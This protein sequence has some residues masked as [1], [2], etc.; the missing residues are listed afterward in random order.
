MKGLIIN[1]LGKPENAMHSTAMDDYSVRTVDQETLILHLFQHEGVNMGLDDT[2]IPAF[3]KGLAYYHDHDASV[4][5]RNSGG[6]SIVSDSGVLNM[7]LVLKSNANMYDN[8]RYLDQFIR[9]ALS[10]ITHAIDTGEIIGAYC[11]GNSDMSINGRKF[12]GTAQRKRLDSVALVCYIGVNGNQ[13]QRSSLVQGFYE[14]MDYDDVVVHKDFMGT[15]SSLTGLTL[16]VPQVAQLMID[17]LKRRT[18]STYEITGY[19]TTHDAFQTS[20]D[21]THRQNRVLTK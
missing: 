5:V 9:D 20:M 12:C 1:E 16:T 7:S 3:E 2:K 13:D 8:Y 14:A 17:E 4:I 15:L 11:P 18:D 6:R 19:D 10:R 21:M